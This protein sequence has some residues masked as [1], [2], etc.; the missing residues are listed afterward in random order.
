LATWATVAVH[1]VDTVGSAGVNI[2]LDVRDPRREE[3]D[4]PHNKA[5]RRLAIGVPALGC[6]LLVPA[7]AA[8][9]AGPVA[10]PGFTVSTFASGGSLSKPDDITLLNGNVYVSYQNGVGSKGEP[11]PTG[12][13]ASTVVEYSPAGKRLASWSLTGKCDGLTADTATDRLVATVNEDAHSSLF[14]IH[15]GSPTPAH[16]SYSPALA[17]GGGTDAI[18]FL[19]GQMLISASAPGSNT[20]VP[21]VYAVTMS[22][23][24]AHVR[25]VFSD[26]STATPANTGAGSGRPRKLA[27]TDPDSSEVVPAVSA[28][29]SGDFLL[30]GQ[31]DKQLILTGNVGSPSPRLSVLHTSTQINDTA[32]ATAAQGALYIT[33]NKANRVLVVHGSFPTGQAYSA[34]PADSS[35]NPATVG[36]LNLSTGAVSPFVTGLAGP[37]GLTFVPD[38]AAGQ[39]SRVPTG[40]AQ[41]GG[42]S[43]SR[44][45]TG[46][47]VLG[48]LLLLAG[49]GAG[50]AGRRQSRRP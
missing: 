35:V 23:S 33:D 42:G 6:A 4:M 30:D 44:P 49:V 24:T 29:F 14:V 31:G 45:A 17:H 3:P 26:N 1:L 5:L 8:Q 28:R 2:F 21:A 36:T 40:G 46:L 48:G 39:V 25:S 50:V 22:G 27:L 43:T 34:V 15:P 20:A 12:K 9:A 38:A 41:T 32:W 11:G 37:A 47:N 10:P 18:T 19:H 13:T 7:A 16:Y